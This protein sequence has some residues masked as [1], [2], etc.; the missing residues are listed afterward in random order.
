MA[1]GGARD[2]SGRKA[3]KNRATL[4]A[5]IDV[6]HMKALDAYKKRHKLRSR[7]E[8]VRRLIDRAGA[9]DK[10]AAKRLQN[11]RNRQAWPE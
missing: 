9:A 2:G 1:K 10:G 3:F 5:S 6:T 8:A 11:A 4:Y 7:S